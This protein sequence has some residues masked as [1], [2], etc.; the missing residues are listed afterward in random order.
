MAGAGVATAGIALEPAGWVRKT[1]KGVG[2]EGRPEPWAGDRGP[3][4]GFC[5]LWFVNTSA[6][7]LSPVIFRISNSFR[8]RA[9]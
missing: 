6:G 2:T 8:R 1:R 3:T 5:T 9:S 4:A 7:F